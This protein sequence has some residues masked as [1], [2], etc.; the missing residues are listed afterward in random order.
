MAACELAVAS[1]HER[2]HD[3]L[4]KHTK[5]LPP[6]HVSDHVAVQNQHGNSPL[7]WDKC[8]V[9]VSVEPYDKYAVKILDSGRLTY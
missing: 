7:K 8:G 5:E 4:S 9:I 3:K 2:C 6:L 1:W